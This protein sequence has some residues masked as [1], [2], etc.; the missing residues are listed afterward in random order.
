MKKYIHF[1]LTVIFAVGSISSDLLRAP[2]LNI[3]AEIKQN[4]DSAK[5]LFNVDFTPQLA[6]FNS[7][8]GVIEY[9][10]HDI[11]AFVVK[12]GTLFVKKSHES[13]LSILRPVS[14]AVQDEERLFSLSSV[15]ENRVPFVSG[16]GMNFEN[17]KGTRNAIY[18]LKFSLNVPRFFVC[19]GK[20]KI[21]L[22]GNSFVADESV[23][24]SLEDDAEFYAENLSDIKHINFHLRGR[25]KVYIKEGLAQKLYISARGVGTSFD[26]RGLRAG[27]VLVNVSN[28]LA[29]KIIVNPQES[30]FKIG[31]SVATNLVSVNSNLQ[32]PSVKNALKHKTTRFFKESVPKTLKKTFKA[33]VLAGGIVVVTAIVVLV[34]VS[35]VASLTSP[36]TNNGSSGEYAPGFIYWHSSPSIDSP[37]SINTRMRHSF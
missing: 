28:G 7:M 24:V 4:I 31:N 5:S 10:R 15:H 2:S 6:V 19:S 35:V 12:D 3:R 17:K 23:D 20:S 8:D 32:T 36:S 11:P 29:G 33:V 16:R 22:M 34:V 1:L 37:S 26:G 21:F 27:K 25:S 14:R 30:F 18:F 9:K 13:S